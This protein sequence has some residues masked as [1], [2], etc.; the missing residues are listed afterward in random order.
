MEIN[1]KYIGIFHNGEELNI[2]T[3]DDLTSIYHKILDDYSQRD[4]INWQVGEPADGIEKALDELLEFGE[5][6]MDCEE[7]FAKLNKCINHIPLK[8]PNQVL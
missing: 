3:S 6:N 8:Y 4:G 2:Y 1:D 7:G 5:E